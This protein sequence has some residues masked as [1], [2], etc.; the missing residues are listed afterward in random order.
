MTALNLV[1]CA[2]IGL[3]S[4]LGDGISNLS[5]AWQILLANEFVQSGH[6]SSPY[7]TAPIGM[8]STHMFTNAV[9]QIV[10][11]LS[12]HDLLETL[13]K[14]EKQM[15]RNRELGKDR[16]IDLDLLIYD[17]LVIHDQQLTLPHPEIQNRLFVLAPFIELAPNLIHP[18]LKLSIR[19]L[20][21]RLLGTGQE[22]ERL[23]WNNE[24]TP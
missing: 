2:Y 17:D 20:G 22:I 24:V 1:H 11:T 19:E 10:T 8:E 16:Q 14:V 15:G 13:L 23:T 3:G 7:L 9:C 18:Q 4:N 21:Q 6:I 12:A 5:K